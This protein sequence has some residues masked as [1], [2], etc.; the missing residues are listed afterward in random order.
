VKLQN[1]SIEWLSNNVEL[2]TKTNNIIII[3]I[4]LTNG[5]LIV[6]KIT[7]I[8]INNNSNDNSI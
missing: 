2:V 6:L 1:E 5:K 4:M 8:N 7:I 3:R